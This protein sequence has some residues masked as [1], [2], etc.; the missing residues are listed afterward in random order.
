VLKSGYTNLGIQT[1][2]FHG[3]YWWFGCYT[4]E[5]KKGLLKADSDLELVCV[6]DVSP[7]F[8]LVGWGEG[9]FL[10]ARH[11][12]EEWQAKVVPMRPDERVGLV[13]AR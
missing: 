11:F 7:A 2:C 13:A 9:R 4:V 6:Y 12:G 1:A 8:G 5:G 3:D 10:V